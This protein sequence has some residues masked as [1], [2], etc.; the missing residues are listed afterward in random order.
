MKDMVKTIAGILLVVA[1]AG[2]GS[3]Q[4]QH[5]Y[6]NF[7]LRGC[8][9]FLSNSVDV[10]PPNL[11]RSTVGTMCFDGN[12]NIIPNFGALDGT[13][14]W[15]TTNGAS[16][17]F[18]KQ[19]GVYAVLNAPGQGMGQI[20]LANGCYYAFSINSVDP[21]DLAHGFQFSLINPQTCPGPNVVGG[22][23]LLQP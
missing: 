20:R 16:L 12:G 6:T 18:A 7:V 14:W 1:L 8:Y 17:A 22:T 21:N 19:G 5:A 23:A 2:V 4:A 3:S 13:G 10:A 9:G 15:Q 11:N